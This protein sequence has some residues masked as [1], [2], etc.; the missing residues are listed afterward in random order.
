[1]ITIAKQ[2]YLGENITEQRWTSIY[3]SIWSNGNITYSGTYT[4]D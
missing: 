2:E 1:M 3:R 4:D